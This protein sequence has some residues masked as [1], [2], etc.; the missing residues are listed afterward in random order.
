[1]KLAFFIPEINGLTVALI[2]EIRN[3]ISVTV[4]PNISFRTIRVGANKVSELS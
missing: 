3:F 2:S 4:F 1:M